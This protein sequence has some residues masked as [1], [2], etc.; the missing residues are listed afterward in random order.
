MGALIS[1]FNKS[2]KEKI[3]IPVEEDIKFI[4]NMKEND[5]NNLCLKIHILGSGE[6]KEFILNNMFK[7]NVTDENLRNKFKVTRQFKTEQFHWIAH[8]YENEI[9]NEETCKEIEKEIKGERANKENAKFILK[10]QVILCFGDQHTELVSSYFSKFRKSNMIFVT[11]TE[12][13][14][15]NGMDKRYATNIIYKNQN[16]KEMSNEDLNIKII[17]LLW[18][19][20]CYFKEKGNIACR[21]TPDNIFNGLENDNA[22][23]TLNILIAGLA[24]VGKSTFINLMSRKLTALESDLKVSVTKNITEYY[25]YN[26]DNKKEHGAI[27][28]ID[29][30]G[31]VSN[32][33]NNDYME[34]ESQIKELIKNQAKSS[35]EKKIHF[36]FFI[37]NKNSKLGFKDANNI[38]E[39]FKVLNESECPVYFIV[40][41]VKK[42]DDPDK[43]ISRFTESLN[44]FGFTNLSKKENFIMANF[45]KGKEGG[46]IHGMDL[47]FSKI[48]NY[49]NDNKYLDE[50]ILSNIE[51][52]TKDYRTHVEA[53]KS[54]LLLTKEDI[55]TNQELKM[56]IK[57]NQRLEEI[58]K[59]IINNN[60]LSNIDINS[61]IE[62]AKNSAKESI[63]VIMSLSK[64]DGVLPSISQNIPAISIY[65]AFMVKEIGARFG[66]DIDIVNAGTKQ[67][68]TFIQ[69]ILPEIGK[70]QKNTKIE[71]LNEID[72]EE[73]KKFI[74]EKAKEKLGQS[75][76]ERNTIFSLADFLSRL[77]NMDDKYQK[78]DNI[79]FSISVY[80]YC[81][82]FFEKEIK[83]SEGLLFI[84]N[85]FNKYKLLMNDIKDYIEKKD[86]DNYDIKIES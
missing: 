63:K 10:N 47:I 79:N 44:Q 28:L 57:F 71:G 74:Q 12:C 3:D 49:I 42:T 84:L 34:K 64:L 76:S 60:L 69:K 11:E 41:K 20:D 7:E 36:I 6:K 51:E 31:L 67:L 16:N 21:Y 59:A 86:W 52:L 77:K 25:I 40:N 78:N 15:S 61:L 80:S 50:K 56:D 32:N 81:I 46:E 24:R 58:K 70:N 68:L 85:C 8:V 82:F 13:K 55:L 14:L 35:F 19:L 9:L 48:L 66:L 2:F 33:N 43:I 5:I 54:F 65:Q 27:K 17:S 29:T 62:N 1:Y 23:F 30:P 45:L 53:D 4:N 73:N 39:V 18:E 22:L 83:E 26:K 38:E 37:L 72:I 75:T